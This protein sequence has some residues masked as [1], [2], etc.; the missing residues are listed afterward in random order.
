M[1]NLASIQKISNLEPIQ[2][3]DAIEKATV[4]GWQL[5]VKKGDFAIN[6]LCVFCEIDSIL[7]EKPE[8]EFLK[9]R[10]FRIKTIKLRGQISQGICFPLSILPKNIK[11]VEGL[12][13]TEILGIEKYEPYQNEQINAK[14]TGKI[15]YPKWM[16]QWLRR[17]IHKFKFV[18]EYYRQNS[19][20]KS[21]PSL[22]P[23]TDETRVQV[24]Q[25][26]IDKYKGVK[27]YY[28]EKLDGSSITVYQINGKF[29]VCSRNID[30][31][32]DNTDKFWK[33][34]LEHDLE[35]K[36][37]NVFGNEN[38]A[39]QGELI[40]EGIQGNK[41]QL[42]GLDIYFYNVFFIKKYAYGNMNDLIE[43]CQKLN[44]KTVPILNDN[45]ELVNSIPELVELSKGK[46]NL[47][48]KTTREGIVIRPLIEIED[49]D[50]HCQL[51]KNRISFKCVNPDFLLEYGE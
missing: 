21:F 40:G 3:A 20:H 36:F 13:V 17:I 19:G 11:I 7:P 44:E 39:L 1:R 45:F 2:N 10:K 38:I 51:V 8:F 46:S 42:K 12:D 22:I 32:R 9:D 25:P 49:T 5:V 4:L 6:D 41:Y 28:S 14:Q 31:N 27:C 16:P 26:L 47:N 15:I 33:T 43:I 18:R 29:G 48:K 37:K 23:K 30:L 50:L 24:L 34:V 35:N